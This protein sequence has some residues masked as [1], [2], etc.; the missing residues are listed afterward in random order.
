MFINPQRNPE[1]MK[2]SF[3]I[4]SCPS[5]WQPLTCPV[6]V[7]PD[8]FSSVQSLSHVQLFAI[9]WTAAHQ[10]FPSLTLPSV[11]LNSCPLMRGCCSAISFP[12]APFSFCL[13]SFSAS[14][15]FPINQLFASGGQ[16]IR[17]SALA[18]V[19]PMNIQGIDAK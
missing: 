3:H 2:Q 18:P 17:A 9:P 14:G 1:P 4:P 5:L 19:L 15:S 13:Q 7:D 8:K 12:T 6:P 11:C 16:S 10:T